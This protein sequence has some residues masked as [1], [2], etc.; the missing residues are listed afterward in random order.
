MSAVTEGTDCRDGDALKVA[1]P[2][3]A[4]EKRKNM[5]PSKKWTLAVLAG[6]ALLTA[7]CSGVKGTTTGGG[8]GGGTNSFTIG[9]SVI[10]LKGTGLV[11]EN[12]GSDTLAIAADGTFT[13]KVATSGA[14]LVIVKTQPTNP[15]QTCSVSNGNGTAGANVINVQVTCG[16]N[17]TIGGTVSGLAGSGLVLQ[18]NTTDNLTVSGTGS[19][20][21]TF[22]TPLAS[23]ATFTVT[24]LTQP[25]NPAQICTVNNGTGPANGTITN[26][27]II[28][29]QPS[30]TISGTVVGLV[31]G[32]GNTVE[33]QDNA[34]DN[35]FITGNNSA[36]TL[37][38]HVTTGGIYNVSVFLEPTSQPQPCNVFNGSGVANGNVSNVLIDCQHNDWAWIF[39][40]TNSNQ[41]ATANLPPPFPDVNNPGGR[42][43]AVTWTD[44]SG[45]KWL[46]GGLGYPLAEAPP[47]PLGFLNDLWV[48]DG[49]WIP[50]NLPILLDNSGKPFADVVPL[51]FTNSAGI[52]NGIGASGN[53]GARWGGVTWTD[54]SGNLWMFGGQG[55]DSTGIETGLLSDTWEF[56][57]GNL[58]LTGTWLGTW[59]WRAGPSTQNHAGTYG[60]Q[61][62]AAAGNI[63]G[64]RWA[65][66]SFVDSSGTLWMFGG[67]GYDSAGNVG[68][69][70][71]LWKFSAGQWTWVAGSNLANQNGAF[72]TLGAAS[73]SNVPGGRQQGVLWVDTGGN[74]WLFGGFGL[75]S[76]GTANGTLNDL[77]EL[78]GGQWT[79]VSGGGATGLANQDGVYGTQL[80]A[81]AT[82]VP[83]SRWGAVGWTDSNNNLWLFGGW[84]YDSLATEGTGFFNDTWEY[85]QSS[86]DWIWWKGSSNVN[87]NGAYLTHN[88]FVDN[89]PGARRGQALWQPDALH[90][91]WV[92][93]GQG[94]DATSATGNGY[95][96]DLWTY[97]P[98][99]N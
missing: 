26:V 1:A 78:K 39:G 84:G 68:L 79:W 18:D 42:D 58:D 65:G 64:G 71:D 75:D 10:G 54:A 60:V 24:I 90:Y 76:V 4:I 28:C 96:S 37:P 45:K 86:G 59:I 34:G 98:Y 73:A 77:W 95:L 72:G 67:Q 51:E 52:Y 47:Q 12:N 48:W 82:N 41:Y 85:Q 36:F 29:P 49:A 27:Q 63:P 5:I 91:I 88:S 87:E 83:G 16:A 53:P 57:P 32:T 7:S 17:F 69:L 62:V 8:G 93:G 31:D 70:N 92:F 23:G 74:V 56:V 13:F 66:A 94:Y 43:F 80:T 30:F 11:I 55:F 20:P 22:A 35:L 14:F 33:L 9:G 61:G 97:L 19:V 15:T 40:P 89:V 38:T 99:P 6:I 25:S 50:A 46:F 81:A 2:E 44:N 3:R 21:F